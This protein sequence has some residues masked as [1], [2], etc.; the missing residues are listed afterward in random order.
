MDI[1]KKR[2]KVCSV[3]RILNI[4]FLFCVESLDDS[5]RVYVACSTLHFSN[6]PVCVK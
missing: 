2:Y 4:V 1:F 6:R 5:L 3:P